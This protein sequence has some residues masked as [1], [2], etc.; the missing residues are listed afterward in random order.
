MHTTLNKPSTGLGAN[1]FAKYT[2]QASFLGIWTFGERNVKYFYIKRSEDNMGF[3]PQM[4]Q[5]G[6]NTAFWA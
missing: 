3:L 5:S 6:E 1:C 4:Y 2:G